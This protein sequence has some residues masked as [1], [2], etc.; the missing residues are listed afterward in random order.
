MQRIWQRGKIQ[1]A[2][3]VLVVFS[4]LKKGRVGR[5]SIPI[6]LEALREIPL[7]DRMAI[8]DVCAKHN[9]NK[10]KVQR[11]LRR[12]LIRRRSSSIKPY[13]TDCNKKT[14]LQWCIDMIERGLS[15][16]PRFKD[17]F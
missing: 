10:W 7:K 1:F 12:S 3:S 9:L 17:F 8:E 15:G 11:Y 14:R 13:P 5:K 2:S 6:D 4:S 16:D